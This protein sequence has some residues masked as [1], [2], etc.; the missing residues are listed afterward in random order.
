ME[1]HGVFDQ[2]STEELLHKLEESGERAPAELIQVLLSRGQEV[3]LPLS[4]I[5]QERQYWEAEDEKLW[6]PVHAVKLLGTIADP[7]ALPQLIESHVLADETGYDWVKEDLPTVFGRI[8]P[9][10]VEPLI[11][12]IRA[13]RGDSEYQWPR[14]DA[15]DGLVAIVMHHPQE[16]DRVLSFLHELFSEGEDLEFL[17]FVASYLLDLNDPSSFPVLEEAFNK[18]LIDEEFVLIEDLQQEE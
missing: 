11:E 1:A 15:A 5:L 8:G 16:R 13:H 4:N 12:F 2:L 14:I 17:G 10:A 7:Q 6:M 3:V 18:G 9:Q